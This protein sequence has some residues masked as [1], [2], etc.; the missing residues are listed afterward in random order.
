MGNYHPDA[1]ARVGSVEVAGPVGNRHFVLPDSW[2]PGRPKSASGSI[3]SI[4][5]RRRRSSR[6]S[7]RSRGGLFDVVRPLGVRD[8]ATVL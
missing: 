2:A 7:F 5:P 4:V 8:V 3:V 1:S 6:A